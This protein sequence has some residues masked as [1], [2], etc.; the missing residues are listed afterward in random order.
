M[1]AMPHFARKTGTVLTP[2]VLGGLM[3]GATVIGEQ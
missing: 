2:L 3:L 1:I